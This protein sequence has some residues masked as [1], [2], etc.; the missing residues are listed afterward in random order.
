MGQ[1]EFINRQLKIFFLQKADF[2]RFLLGLFVVV[3]CLCGCESQEEREF[4]RGL[5]FEKNKDFKSA[6]SAFSRTI[7][8]NPQSP[9]A[10]AA[11]KEGAKIALLE[12]KDFKKATEFYE[13][14][15]IQSNDVTDRV[16]AQKQLA[17]VYFDQL[18]DYSNAIKELNKLLA[19]NLDPKEKVQFRI[20]LA[21]A[22][23]FSN[24]FLQ[25][26][27]EVKDFLKSEKDDDATFQMMVLK[28][29][30]YLAKKDQQKAI[31]A[32]KDILN[33][34][35]ERAVKENAAMTLAVAYEELKDY[36]N[37]VAVMEQMKKYHSMPEYIDLRIKKLLANQKNQPG[38]KGIHR[39]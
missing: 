7:L 35:P 10:I 1:R 23:Y 16:T 5:S 9:S 14:I 25:A 11:A 34:F 26:E 24:N 39:K 19:T 18:A 27:S 20:K 37:A 2:A 33:T 3:V 29:N 36:K 38:A 28:G 31:E 17:T 12:L 13:T 32:F 30:I 15:V 8:R 21:K 22:Y 4:S 6:I